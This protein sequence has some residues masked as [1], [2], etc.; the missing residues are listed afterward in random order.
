MKSQNIL[1]PNPDLIKEP[2]NDYSSAPEAISINDNL[3]KTMGSS[4]GETEHATQAGGWAGTDDS[5]S[6]APSDVQRSYDLENK[7]SLEE[8]IEA[9]NST[10]R[11]YGRGI[12]GANDTA[13]GAGG[14]EEAV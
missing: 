3:D 14:L 8:R 2:L 4:T 7:W 11:A 9:E 10:R 13:E 5:T 1:N 12:D 6:T